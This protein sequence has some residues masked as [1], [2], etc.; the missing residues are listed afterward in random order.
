M[1]GQTVVDKLFGR[2]QDPVG[3]IVRIK[4]V[5]FRVIG[6]LAAKGQTSWG[7]DQDDVVMIP[8][9]TA[10]RRVLGTADPRQRRH[11]LRSARASDGRSPEAADADRATCCASATASSRG[12]DDDFT[13]PQPRARWRASSDARA[14]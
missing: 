8:F 1:L 2:G 5:P 4:N 13:R 12:E 7:Q 14:R 3:A 11:D 10:E 6:V 9:S